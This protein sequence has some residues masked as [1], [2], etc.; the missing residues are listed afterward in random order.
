MPYIKPHYRPE[1]DKLLQPLL[2]HL[3]QFPLEKQDG[4]VNYT[5]TRILKAVYA[6]DNYFTYNRSMGTL[7][8]LQSEWYRRKIAPYEDKKIKENGDV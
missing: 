1:I 2:A 7:A 8:A 3:M 5:V 6:D 4:A